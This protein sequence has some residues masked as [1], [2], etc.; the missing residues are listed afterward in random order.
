M[1][2][3]RKRVRSAKPSTRPPK[4]EGGEGRGAA[5]ASPSA[6]PPS[7]PPPKLSPA[8]WLA[9]LA[10]LAGLL[11]A[12]YLATLRKPTLAA[13]RD[14]FKPELLVIQI[15]DTYRVD[16]VGNGRRGGLGRVAA[17]VRQARRQHKEVLI[18]HAG[19][20]LAPSLES[21]L[22]RGRQMVDAL[23]YLQTLAP[24]W[25]VPGNHEF[26]D[27]DRTLLLDA[28]DRSRFRWFASNLTLDPGGQMLHNQ[29][30]P[31]DV[32]AIGKLRLGVF[33]LTLH[34]AQQGG[35]QEYARIGHDD[36]YEIN[37]ETL[38]A[39]AQEVSAEVFA[40]VARLKGR[41]FRSRDELLRSLAQ[42]KVEAADP[43]GDP[44]TNQVLLNAIA[45]LA[46]VRYVRIAE[47]QI[48]Q[49][50]RRGANVIIGLTHLDMTDDRQVARLR[51][52]HP[53]F[54]WVAGGH[55]HYAQRTRLTREA[56]LITKADSNA[57]SVWQVSFGLKDG[58][59][60]VR[61]EKI[62]LT[63]RPE[64]DEGYERDIVADYRAQLRQR[65]PY[66]DWVV[67]S[68]KSVGLDC[69]HATEE[70]VRSEKSNWGTYLAEQ[71]RKA[72][73][74]EA[75]IG[76]FNGGSIRLDDIVC[77]DIRFEHLER[78]FGFDARVVHVEIRGDDLR[79]DILEQAVAGKRGDGSFLQV[80]GLRFD[81][82]RRRNP[83]ERVFNV[84]VREEG[85][86]AALDP[87]RVYT[88]AVPEYLFECNDGYRFREKIIR[89]TPEECGQRADLRTLVYNALRQAHRASG[90]EAAADGEGV[91]QLPEYAQSLPTAA[92]KW[93]REKGYNDCSGEYKCSNKKK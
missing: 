68:D 75:Q 32:V 41:E 87:G 35:D 2:R 44:F 86:W 31:N 74:P 60:E 51:R 82:N 12:L 23:N 30:V 73:S 71:M 13:G 54:V 55:E 78:T 89:M 26:D 48:R 34:G 10:L 21:K 50:E 45:D 20:F 59:P 53:N 93:T 29:V 43:N 36:R 42:L 72:Y 18:V 79:R 46:S 83:G 58:A 19:D 38:D 63:G 56:A 33:A 92:V 57:R 76:I 6:P 49:L 4:V 67:G 28:I 27:G 5:A 9:L 52:A 47:E 17:L 8:R 90:P 61:E 15:N 3:N 77:G 40:G 88:V 39:L 25:V 64:P 16:A 22:F 85:K 81:Y 62:D 84:Q 65:L 14:D 91:F 80:A 70:T 24:V 7:P 11:G 37:E 1:S 69:L 66:I